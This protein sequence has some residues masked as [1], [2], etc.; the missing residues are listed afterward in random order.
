[1]EQEAEQLYSAMQV[2]KQP[3]VVYLAQSPCFNRVA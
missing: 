2:F 3:I 1:M